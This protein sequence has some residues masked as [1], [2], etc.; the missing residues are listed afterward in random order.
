MLTLPMPMVTAL[1]LGLLAVEARLRR[2]PPL[3][4]ALLAVCALQGVVVSLGQYYLVPGFARVQPVTA[5]AV[6]VLAWVTFRVTAIGPLPW[7]RGAVHLAV[8]AFT[9][10]CAVFAPVAL[11]AAVSGAFLAYGGAI[12]ALLVR[13][14]A[15]ALP[16]MRLENGERSDFVWR[17]IAAALILS[18]IS[19]GL[20]AVAAAAGALWLKGWIFGLFSTLSLLC[21]GVLVLSRS[22]VGDAEPDAGPAAAAPAEGAAADEAADRALVAR[23]AD[24]METERLYLDPALTLARLARRLR[25]PAKALS[26]AINRITGENVSRFVNGHRVRHACAC[27]AAG[28]SVTAAMLDS[29]FNT[30][31]NFNREFQR[32]TGCAPSLWPAAGALAGD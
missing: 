25:V 26:G 2:R 6:P 32:V 11:D 3:F 28:E 22:L 8:P 19:D 12:L 5:T 21:I 13:G 10:F 29:G 20:I 27:L 14:G 31:S 15:D 16:L 30:R 18:G 17:A 9:A 7:R 4:S 23:L 24:L 1:I